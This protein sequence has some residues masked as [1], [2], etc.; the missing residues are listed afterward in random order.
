MLFL[1]GEV[2]VKT[3]EGDYEIK[4]GDFVTFAKGLKCTWIVK[5]QVRKHYNF[6]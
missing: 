3:E 4:A 1:E 6:E 2:T 5:K